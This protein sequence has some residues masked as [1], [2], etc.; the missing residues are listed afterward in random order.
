MSGVKTL[1]IKPDAT[2]KRRE[3]A[4]NTPFVMLVDD[5]VPFVET[6]TKR[7]AKRDLNV[8]SA[9][10]GQEALEILDYQRNVDVV[11]LDV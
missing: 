4:M 8:I 2:I 6:M 1:G 11:I 10:S 5:E 9:F 7:L 3:N